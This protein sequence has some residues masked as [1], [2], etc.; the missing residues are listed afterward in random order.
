MSGRRKT[1]DGVTTREDWVSLQTCVD[2][3][4]GGFGYMPLLDSLLRFKQL[5]LLL[6]VEVL[7]FFFSRLDPVL[8]KDP[9]SNLR[10]KYKALEGV[11]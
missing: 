9:V 10:K 4:A 1:R 5:A 3:F 6:S 11:P 8:F 7:I 2:Q